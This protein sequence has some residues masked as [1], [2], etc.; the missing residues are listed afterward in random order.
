MR[1][2]MK[3]ETIDE[4]MGLM[5]IDSPEM[6]EY[7]RA[8]ERLKKR[9]EIVYEDKNVLIIN[10][11][12]GVLAQK[13]EPKNFSCNEWL[14]GYLLDTKCITPE[15]LHTFKP[16]ICNRLDKFTSG[17]LICGKTLLGTQR[18]NELIRERR[19]RKYYRTIVKGEFTEKMHIKGYLVRNYATN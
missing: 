19:I 17:L 8:Y 6:T 14:I 11:P 18:M 3:D 2:Y 4:F 12:A 13:A 7:R 5:A 15:Q 9:I 1:L 10:K 16:S